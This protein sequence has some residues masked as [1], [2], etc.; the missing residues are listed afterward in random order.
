MQ[1]GTGIE[2]VARIQNLLTNKQNIVKRLFSENEYNY[3]ISKVVPAQ[4]FTGIWCAKSA[5][6]K[7]LS[8]VK[9]IN[10]RDIHINHLPCGAPIIA[11]MYGYNIT[12]SIAHTNTYAT[13][14]ALAYKY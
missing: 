7:A 12:V 10:L 3:A 9:A 8:S 6:V 14:V 11:P 1:I 4:S 5:V 2:S 13:A